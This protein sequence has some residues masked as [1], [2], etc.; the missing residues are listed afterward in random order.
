MPN[1][2]YTSRSIQSADFHKLTTDGNDG[3]GS[4]VYALTNSRSPLA[5]FVSA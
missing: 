5:V 4:L 3:S 1:R 2:S